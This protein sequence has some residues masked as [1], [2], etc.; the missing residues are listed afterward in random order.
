MAGH[1]GH[2]RPERLV[3]VARSPGGYAECSIAWSAV[4]VSVAVGATRGSRRRRR[5]RLLAG[6]GDRRPLLRPPAGRDEAARP[7]LAR[8][9]GRIDRRGHDDVPPPSAVPSARDCSATSTGGRSSRSTASSSARC[10]AT[11]RRPPRRSSAEGGDWHG[12]DRARGTPSASQRHPQA[13][14][15]G[16]ARRVRRGPSADRLD[17][18]PGRMVRGWQRQQRGRPQGVGP[19]AVRSDPALG[20]RSCSGRPCPV[21]KLATALWG[22]QSEDDGDRLR[23]RLGAG[24]RVVVYV[25]LAWSAAR[26]AAG[27]GTSSAVTR[28]RRV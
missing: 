26:V 9:A 20:H 4:R 17:R 5:S 19:R 16:R 18:A 24:G 25:A 23:K 10:S 15:P 22:Y 14:R 21:G 27:S 7:R 28:R 12:T 6:R 13:R 11:S 1:R 2:R 8:A 3:L